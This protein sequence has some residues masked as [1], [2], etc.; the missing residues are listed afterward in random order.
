MTWWLLMLQIFAAGLA[1]F[2]TWLLRK[3]GRRMPFAFVV[4]LVSNPAAM[5]VMALQG[6][7]PFFV[8]H[9]VF[10]WWAIES[11]WHWLVKPVFSFNKSEEI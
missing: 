10:F 8:M 5:A 2:G 6:N 7:W 4:W 11:V 1:M 9:L 3:P